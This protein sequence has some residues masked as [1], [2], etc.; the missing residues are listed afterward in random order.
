[1]VT[2][3]DVPGTNVVLRMSRAGSMHIVVTDKNG[4]PMG[5]YNGSAVLVEVAPKNGSGI[6]T[7]GAS[8]QVNKEDGTIEFN[9]VP[10]GEYRV[11]SRPNPA[12]SNK[13]YAPE[14]IIKVESGVRA[15]VTIGY[16]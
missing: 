9:N 7:W 3:Y 13:Q 11:T 4:K 15:S 10:A 14:Q 2:I 12:N 16:E 5:A 1:M 8:G 6:G